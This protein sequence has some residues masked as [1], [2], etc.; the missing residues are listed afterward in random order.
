MIA[1]YAIL[2][3]VGLAVALVALTINLKT[4]AGILQVTTYSLIFAGLFY[5]IGM[6]ALLTKEVL[7]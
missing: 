4:R 6:L 3:G 2:A 1:E 5:A 7:G